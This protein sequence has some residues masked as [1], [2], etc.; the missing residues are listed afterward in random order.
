[1]RHGFL[2]AAAAAALAIGS[3]GSSIAGPKLGG[4]DAIGGIDVLSVH[5]DCHQNLRTHGGSYPEHYHAGA[6]CAMVTTNNNGNNQNGGY[7][8]GDCHADVRNHWTSGYGT[9][10][11]RHGGNCG[12]VPYENQTGPTPGVGGC[13]SVGNFLTVCPP[14]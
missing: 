6:N 14:N 12:V 7:N 3:I 5:N 11:H 10:W 9:L 8:P 4:G 1:M 2:F 13:V